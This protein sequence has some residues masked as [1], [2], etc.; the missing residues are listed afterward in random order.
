MHGWLTDR[1]RATVMTVLAYLPLI[2]ALLAALIAGALL[3]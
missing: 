3:R 1:S 2:L